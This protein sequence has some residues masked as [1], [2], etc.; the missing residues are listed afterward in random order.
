MTTLQQ[1]VETFLR[2]AWFKQREDERRK[3]EAVVKQTMACVEKVRIPSGLQGQCVPYGLICAHWR[4]TVE[5]SK[6]LDLPLHLLFPDVLHFRDVKEVHVNELACRLRD[7]VQL[8]WQV[9]NACSRQLPHHEHG[10]AWL[11][12]YVHATRWCPMDD[13]LLNKWRDM[14]SEGGKSAADQGV[15][16]TMFLTFATLLP[17]DKWPHVYAWCIAFLV[18]SADTGTFISGAAEPATEELT[19]WLLHYYDPEWSC[20]EAVALKHLSTAWRR[21]LASKADVLPPPTTC[22]TYGAFE[23]A[24]AAQSPPPPPL[25]PNSPSE[26]TGL[27]PLRMTRKSALYPPMFCDPNRLTFI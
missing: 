6:K 25:A 17:S 16:E 18:H 4:D 27:A 3:K 24:A 15:V 8:R 19:E 26:G 21:H 1:V 11:S 7:D 10:Q 20:D 22:P 13:K 5:L 12:V 2:Q 23:A 9:L 14:L